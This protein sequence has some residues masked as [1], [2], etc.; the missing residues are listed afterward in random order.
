[1]IDTGEA[2]RKLAL[3]VA[4]LSGLAPL[5]RPLIG[6]V[7]A[8]LMLHRVT[9]ALDRPDGVNRHLAITPRFLDEVVGDM[10]ASG[11]AFITMDEMVERL[12]RGA[13]GPQF[14]TI[15]AD[16]GYR[17]N[18]TEALPILERHAAPITIYV[19]PRLTDR[20]TFLWWAVIDDLVEAV[21]SLSVPSGDGVVELDCSTPAKKLA[22][23]T[24]LHNHL[25]TAVNEECRHGFIADLATRYGI[26]PFAPSVKTLMDWDEIRT[27]AA[28]PLVTIGAHSVSHLNLRRLP[29]EVARREIAEAPAIIAEQTGVV[30]RHMAY[31]YGYAQ[32]VG[33]REVKLAAEAGFA[34]AVTTR[35][36]IIRAEH[37][38]HLHA[39]PRISLNGRYQRL[40]HLRTM[41]TGVTT[42]LANA[43]KVV[44]TV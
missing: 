1:M 12:K 10:K 6:G 14:A 16:D 8:I 36:G 38:G 26:D 40:E 15:T 32:A 39:L 18:L 34:S 5:A 41:L 19:A 31:P 23:N 11:Y 27:I 7:G 35:H 3:N 33:C 24:F 28:H 43:G 25:V 20:S 22:A 44:V 4:R 13:G 29:E 37:A 2:I 30:P 17:D 21:E 9:S 42:P